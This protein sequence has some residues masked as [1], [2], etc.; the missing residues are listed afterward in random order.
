MRSWASFVVNLLLI[1]VM[2]PALRHASGRLLHDSGR[3]IALLGGLVAFIVV[4]AFAAVKVRPG[5]ARSWCR[6]RSS[7]S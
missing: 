7:A 4:L 2:V 1:T 6:S 3:A 5:L